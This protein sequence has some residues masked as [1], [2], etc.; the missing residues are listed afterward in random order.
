MFQANT[1]AFVLKSLVAAH[2]VLVRNHL[3]S[4]TFEFWS[5]FGIWRTPSPITLRMQ[6]SI[7]GARGPKPPLPSRRH[8]YC[9]QHLAHVGASPT[10]EAPYTVTICMVTKESSDLSEL[11]SL[12]LVMARAVMARCA[13]CCP[14][15]KLPDSQ[16]SQHHRSQTEPVALG[17]SDWEGESSQLQTCK[18]RTGIAKWVEKHRAVTSS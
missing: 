3:K 12:W 6:R 2:L 8:C 13:G 15:A 9:T 7:S 1:C 5:E 4:S 14:L 10:R 17:G 16:T 11:L 18:C